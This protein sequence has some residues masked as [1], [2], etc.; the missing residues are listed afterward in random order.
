MK[1]LLDDDQLNEYESLSY[2][3]QYEYLCEVFDSKQCHRCGFWVHNLFDGICQD[4]EYEVEE[5]RRNTDDW[6]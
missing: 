4:C 1:E 5:E 2:D 3:Q 6:Y